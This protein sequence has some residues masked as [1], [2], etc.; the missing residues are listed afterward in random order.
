[1]SVQTDQFSILFFLATVVYA[2]VGSYAYALNPKAT[3]NRLFFLV[4][5]S[6]G[7]WAFAFAMANAA[8][9]YGE[10]LLWR[11]VASF[12]W[13]IVYSI[14]L[15]FFL[16]LTKKT[17]LLKHRATYVLLYLPAALN[18]FLFGIYGPIANTQ[19]HLIQLES[20]WI[21]VYS[22]GVGEFFFNAYYLLFSLMG[23][24]AVWNW[25]GLTQD[26]VKKRTAVV[27]SVT[28]F[29]G[30]VL[31]TLTDVLANQYL[32]FYVPQLGIIFA[33][34]PIAGVLYAIK[35]HSLMTNLS[36]RAAGEKEILTAGNRF[37]FYNYLSH[38]VVLGS[39]VNLTHYFY[40][41]VEVESVILLSLFLL[42]VGLAVKFIPFTSL[43]VSKQD[44]LLFVA[45]SILTI[46][47]LW[48][49]LWDYGNNIVWAIP[50]VLLLTTAVFR[51]IKFFATVLFFT[52]V[53]HLMAW[54]AAPVVTVTVD[55][56]DYLL[57]MVLYLFVAMLVYYINKIYAQKLEEHDNQVAL[58]KKVAEISSDLI[59]VGMDSLDDKIDTMLEK[60]GLFLGADRAYLF[61]VIEDLSVVECTNEWCREGVGSVRRTLGP[62][63]TTSLTWWLKSF[64]SEGKVCIRD[65]ADE[66][67]AEQTVLTSLN[68]KSLIS[69]PVYKH[70]KLLGFLGV[71]TVKERK[72]WSPEQQGA[73][74]IVGNSVSDAIAKVEAERQINF[75]AYYDAL[76]NLPNRLYFTRELDKRIERS[77]GRETYMGILLMDL[78]DFKS[79]NDTMG[80]DSGD[81]LLL[82][83][84]RRL[85]RIT[86]SSDTVCRFGGDAFLILLPE[87]KTHEQIEEMAETI[88]RVFDAPV[89]VRAQNFYVTAS[90][91]VAVYP[92]DGQDSETLIK[93]ADLAM[94]ASKNK[95]K[96]SVVFCTTQMKAAV[97]E[98]VALSNDL[99]KALENDELLLHYQPQV[100]IESGDIIGLEAL[101][102]WRHPHRGLVSPGV[103]IPLAEQSGLINKIGEWVLK[104]ACNQNKKW[105]SMGFSPVVMA[106]NLSVEQF[107]GQKL[108][109]LVSDVLAESALAPHYLELEITESVAIKEPR[110]IIEVLRGL[111]GLGVSL[112][113]DDFGTEYSSLSRLKELPIDRL[114]MAM[115]FVQGIGRG[116]DDEAIA[117][118]IINLA[119]H[120]GLR[121]IAEGVEDARQLDFLKEQRCDDIQGYYFYRPMPAEEIEH[122]LPKRSADREQPPTDLKYER[123]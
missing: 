15:H 18:V 23:L 92:L 25:K 12:G 26:L 39:V 90:C 51:K 37:K 5:L 118:V 69:V 3:L 74:Q 1:M 112:S 30:V 114:K 65:F 56:L 95:G 21:N 63:K 48:R 6:L 93:S 115:E 58:Q 24:I 64:T 59:S 22:G 123:D 101:I 102:R 77:K 113:I 66:A 107:R 50:I 117:A 73:L 98:K 27:I 57:H 52:V 79:I 109:T 16:L 31:G 121:V 42:V 85:T 8:G 120:L 84:A 44:T 96:N 72:N 81:L 54:R 111:K 70:Q 32:T 89:E 13:G 7:V 40:Y 75:M 9:T 61:K 62:L 14:L 34:I 87:R 91:G 76:T 45:L 99:Y 49:F 108:V 103:F 71:D 104:T 67:P 11:R 33:A 94:Y 82:E 20:G 105:Q 68:V 36:L 19:Y 47:L 106:V 17:G 38:A 83:V 2:S 80:R 35:A 55:D 88:S 10:S 43:S 78:D 116:G 110:S 97:E 4:C 28:F 29:A 100:A 53:L 46:A 86:K 60:S 122:I 41:T 119:K